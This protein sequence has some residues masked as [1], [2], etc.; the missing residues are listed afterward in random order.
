M[1]SNKILPS[2]Y[3]LELSGE[4]ANLE[5]LLGS[6]FGIESIA[7]TSANFES[8]IHATDAARNA[9]DFFLE[10][11]RLDMDSVDEDYQLNPDFFPTI[12]PIEISD[13]QREEEAAVAALAAEAAGEDQ[14]AIV[15]TKRFD[16]QGDHVSAK[17]D[18]SSSNFS[19]KAKII[20]QSESFLKEKAIETIEKQSVFAGPHREIESRSIVH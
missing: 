8:D 11:T 10:N 20:A 4:V 13:S 7:I 6:N 2:F 3:T 15:L 14:I 12:K 9:V 1:I 17:L 16:S 19:L 5:F 18:L